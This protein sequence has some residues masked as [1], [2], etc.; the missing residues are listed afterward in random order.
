MLKSIIMPPPGLT[1]ISSGK[2]F[3]SSR[4]NISDSIEYSKYSIQSQI[5]HNINIFSFL[6]SDK[7]EKKT[8]VHNNSAYCNNC[9]KYGHTIHS[10]KMSITSIGIICFRINPLMNTPE[11]LMIRRRDTLGYIDF[12]RGKYSVYNKSYIMNMLKQMTNEEKN[13]LKTHNFQIL[14]NR[15][16]DCN[17]WPTSK[18]EPSKNQYNHEEYVSKDKFNTLKNG[19]YSNQ[20]F[21]NLN[22]LIEESQQYYSWEDAEWGFP[23]GR[24][25]YQEKDY[26][27]A[28]REFCEETGYLPQTIIPLK[29][30]LPFEESFIGSN[31]KSYNHKYYVKY[32]KYEDS[33]NI[34]SHQ[35]SEVS[36]VEWKP[37]E[38]AI[39]SIRS[40]NIEKINILQNVNTFILQTPYE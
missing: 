12:M 7:S 25:N 21:Y 31:Y 16:W 9:G 26:D 37:F 15:L 13:N 6:P 27:C 29:N 2:D 14:W 17:E 33:I 8:Y 40:Y 10:C 24:R 11:Y 22:L 32:M 18:L 30:I 20:S 36:M 1:N 34:P 38:N 39:K 3:R 23:K 35:I 28:I 19:V 4:N 5:D